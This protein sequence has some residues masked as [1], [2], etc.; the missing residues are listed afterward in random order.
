MDNEVVIS[1]TSTRK[2]M[3][4]NAGLLFLLI[5]IL[6]TFFSKTI[7]SLL[8]P[9]VECERPRGGYL[10]TDIYASGEVKSRD[11]QK[12]FAYGA[13]NIVEVK[14]KEGMEVSKG[15]TLAI[16]DTD[17][18]LLDLNRTEL[19]IL[20]MENDLQQYREN[21]SSAENQYEEQLALKSVENAQKEYENANNLYLIGAE[22]EKNVT[23][24]AEKLDNAK[25]AYEVLLNEIR[26]KESDYKRNL[27][28]KEMELKLKKLELDNAEK[29]LPQNGSIIAPIDGIIKTVA[30]NNGYV[31]GN[32]QVLFEIIKK[33]APLTI[34]WELNDIKAKA[35]KAGD[36]VNFET[37]SGDNKKVVEDKITGKQYSP[38]D[39]MYIF[40]SD[41]D[42]DD[43][44]LKEG[45]KVAVNVTQ[46][47]AFYKF[48][49]KNSSISR[50][51]QQICIFVL[52]ERDGV[53][54]KENY[55]IS[56]PV[57]VEESDDLNSAI[58][59]YVSADDDIVIFSSKALTD[60]T[61]VKLR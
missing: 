11:I 49:L 48:I 20:K 4:R 39:G 33:D 43:A 53:L 28:E 31:A 35:L 10:Q 54:G 12:T 41:V 59:G 21:N 60:G 27:S 56:V 58:S 51:G 15:S 18:I 50:Q 46:K 24:A 42:A 2:K 26:K 57:K 14:V 7:N 37:G 16:I 22:T 32:G 8:M 40:T 29:K 3:I 30:V 1:K 23:N 34:E 5:I 17:N 61:Q 44:D 55:V 36:A 19:D 6:L 9:E 52:K 25:H 47:S 13:W 45:Q 38:K